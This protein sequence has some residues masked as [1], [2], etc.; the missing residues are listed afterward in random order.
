MYG[1]RVIANR[2]ASWRYSWA[3][4]EI[5]SDDSNF[6]RNPNRMQRTCNTYVHTGG[7]GQTG[8][9]IPRHLWYIARAWCPW[10]RLNH[11][12]NDYSC[13]ISIK[14]IVISR[15]NSCNVLHCIALYNADISEEG[16]II[17]IMRRDPCLGQCYQWFCADEMVDNNCE[18]V[19]RSTRKN[20]ALI[21]I[22]L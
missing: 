14:Q 4:C 18:R 10:S 8:R 21:F 19:A 22:V 5:V 12:Y 3:S 20:D 2:R 11:T 7:I 13:C 1:Q 16:N 17:I 15:C 9:R 6:R